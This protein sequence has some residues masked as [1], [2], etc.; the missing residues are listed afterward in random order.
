MT[1]VQA[2]KIARRKLSLLT[3]RPRLEGAPNRRL[4]PPALLR[5]PAQLLDP[6]RRG[7]ARPAAGSEGTTPEPR[8]APDQKG[9]PS[10]C[11]PAPNRRG[12]AS[13]RRADA[14]RALGPFKPR[15]HPQGRRQWSYVHT[16][17]DCSHHVPSRTDSLAAVLATESS[18]QATFLKGSTANAQLSK[19]MQGEMR[20]KKHHYIPRF[21]LKRFPQRQRQ[22]VVQRQRVADELMLREL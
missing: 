14:P 8:R 11:A 16:V 12:P 21:Q 18:R 6:W 13:G 4:Q 19:R 7:A 22:P 15:W 1:T 9:D 20:S 2:E 10:P 17:V 5:E 3:V